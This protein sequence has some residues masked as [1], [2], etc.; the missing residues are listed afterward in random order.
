MSERISVGVS[1]WKINNSAFFWLHV[2]LTACR[3]VSEKKKYGGI[4]GLFL[5]CGDSLFLHIA[6]TSTGIHCTAGIK[7]SAWNWMEKTFLR[8]QTN[9]R[10]VGKLKSK[11]GMHK[12]RKQNRKLLCK[13]K[14]EFVVIFIPA[15]MVRL[16]NGLN[17]E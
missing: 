17:D 5:Q 7:N 13:V 1:D 12:K 11:Y 14:P 9:N 15:F 10:K 4:F 8:M 3:T 2:E 16:F 6:S